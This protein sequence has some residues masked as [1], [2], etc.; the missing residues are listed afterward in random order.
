MAS[1]ETSQLVLPIKAAGK[2]ASFQPSSIAFSPRWHQLRR[3]TPEPSAM[4]SSFSDRQST[5]HRGG[6]SSSFGTDPCLFALAT[7]IKIWNLPQCSRIAFNLE[8]QAQLNFDYLG[9]GSRD[10]SGCFDRW[11]ALGFRFGDRGAPAKVHREAWEREASSTCTR[12]GQ[13]HQ[14]PEVLTYYRELDHETG[15]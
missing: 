13:Q 10:Q 6:A 15:L 9:T 8:T 1:P 14:R 7:A 3:L 11:I 2:W 4:F 12:V 5:Q